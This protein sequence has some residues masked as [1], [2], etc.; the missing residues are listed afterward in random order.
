MP[1]GIIIQDWVMKTNYALDKELPTLP[2]LKRGSDYTFQFNYE[3]E[4]Q[5]ALYF[6][7]IF[8]SKDE[9]V[10]SS[11]IIK[12]KEVHVNYPETAHTYKVQMIN[13]AAQIIRFEKFTITEQRL[14]DSKQRNLTISGVTNVDTNEAVRNVVFVEPSQWLDYPI[15][16]IC[17][18]TFKEC[19]PLLNIGLKLSRIIG[20]KSKGLYRETW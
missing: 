19:N 12:D 10:L 8:Y 6:K 4:P 5:G 2:I 17:S 11:Q 1:S 3:V 7:I 15:V 9:T 13:A 14:I 16:A 20:M 18:V